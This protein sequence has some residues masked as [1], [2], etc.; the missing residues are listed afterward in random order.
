MASNNVLAI[1]PA[2]AGSKGIKLKNFRQLNGG[3]SPTSLAMIACS[4]A[5][6]PFVVAS[7]IDRVSLPMGVSRKE[8]LWRPPELAQDDT[9]MLDVVKH[10]LAEIPGPDD[11]IVLLVQPTQPLRQPKHLRAAIDLLE[12]RWLDSVVS[13]VE[14]PRTHNPEWQL[15]LGDDGSLLRWTAGPLNETIG[16]RRQDLC[17]TFIRDGT[18]YGFHRRTVSQF[19]NIYGH[20]VLPLIIP[21]SESCALDTPEDW[22]EAERRLRG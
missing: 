4:A 13:V 16:T 10:A 14:L 5:D 21:A 17:R 8:Y 6:V 18:V 12:S 20:E 1:I 2:R 11:Q 22:A 19:G 9:P 15:V 7:D 3:Y